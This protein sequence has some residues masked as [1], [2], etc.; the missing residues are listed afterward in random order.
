MQ[1]L[2]RS[3]AVDNERLREVTVTHRSSSQVLCSRVCPGGGS[4]DCGLLFLLGCVCVCVQEMRDLQG[5]C[6]ALSKENDE[7]EVRNVTPSSDRMYRS[8]SLARLCCVLNWRTCGPPRS[9]YT[10]CWWN[11]LYHT[12]L[13]PI[14]FFS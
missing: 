2:V 10:I 6:E 12:P 4:T 8:V 1:Q 9:I 5:A 7:L 11:G 13:K 14:C 3:L